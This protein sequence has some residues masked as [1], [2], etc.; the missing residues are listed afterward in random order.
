MYGPKYS[1]NTV[2]NPAFAAQYA[3]PAT[4]ATTPTSEYHTL[5]FHD[6]GKSSTG[7][8]LTLGRKWFV[9]P[10]ALPPVAPVSKYAGQPKTRCAT[11]CTI[12]KGP[13][14]MAERRLRFI[15]P[16]ISPLT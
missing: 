14:P 13:S 3:S 1:A 12:A 7:P 5:F 2:A 9:T 6:P 11:S 8:V 15:V 10:R 16:F 4:T